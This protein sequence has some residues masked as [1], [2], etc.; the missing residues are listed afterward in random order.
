VLFAPRSTKFWVANASRDGQPAATQKYFSFQISE[1][2][3]RRP[4][5]AA[6]EI[7]LVM[8]ASGD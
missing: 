1:L 2:L 8:A 3:K 4:D 7:P 6:A 5:P